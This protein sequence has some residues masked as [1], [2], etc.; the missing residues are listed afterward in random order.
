MPTVFIEPEK[1]ETSLRFRFADDPQ[2]KANIRQG[3]IY[4]IETPAIKPNHK[5]YDYHNKRHEELIKQERS[6]LNFCIMCS[7][8]ADR[9]LVFG[10]FGCLQVQKYCTEC[11]DKNIIRL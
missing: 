4:P 6:K 3:N 7:R 10:N 2:R 9:L 5:L 1:V 11:A 8:Q